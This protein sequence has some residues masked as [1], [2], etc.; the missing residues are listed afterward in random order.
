MHDLYHE[1]SGGN[2]TSTALAS[3]TFSN[4]PG[5]WAL[6]MGV[7][8]NTQ[9]IQG[10]TFLQSST[11]NTALSGVIRLARADTLGWRNEADDANLVL[12]VNDSNNLLFGTDSVVLAEATQT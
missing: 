2:R 7:N 11:A 9:S 1:T 5:I 3:G 12:A 4:I 8:M 6:S 10:V